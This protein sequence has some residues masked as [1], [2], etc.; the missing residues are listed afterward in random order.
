MMVS[1]K[2]V[3]VSQKRSLGGSIESFTSA[4]P[5]EQIIIINHYKKNPSPVFF[6]FFLWKSGKGL[7]RQMLYLLSQWMD[8]KNLNCIWKLKRFFII[9]ASLRLKNE[10]GERQDSLK[11][12]GRACAGMLIADTQTG[13][14]HLASFRYIVMSQSFYEVFWPRLIFQEFLQVIVGDHVRQHYADCKTTVQSP[15]KTQTEQ[16][17]NESQR[18]KTEKSNRPTVLYR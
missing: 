1:S 5:S 3:K 12:L 6:V 7:L 15:D 8:F 14:T 2:I 4:S 16:F 17:G 13:R 10:M 9:V 11:R 18:V